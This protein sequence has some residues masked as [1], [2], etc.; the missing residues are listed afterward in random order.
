M[1][2]SDVKI[3]K[4]PNKVFELSWVALEKGKIPE[5]KKQYYTF[6]Q[7]MRFANSSK[8]APAIK[9]RCQYF[10]TNGGLDD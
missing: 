3:I 10:M 9:E 4:R 6:G 5:T 2:I 7:L 8:V 1:N